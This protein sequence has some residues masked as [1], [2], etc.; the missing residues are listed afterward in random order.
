MATSST[1]S[2]DSRRQFLQVLIPADNPDQ[3]L[4]NIEDVRKADLQVSLLA[5]SENFLTH[6]PNQLKKFYK[7][8]QAYTDVRDTMIAMSLQGRFPEVLRLE[9]AEGAPDFARASQDVRHAKS[10][11]LEAESEQKSGT[12]WNAMRHACLEAVGLF[13]MSAVFMASLLASE[14]KAEDRA[15]EAA[16]RARYAGRERVAIPSCV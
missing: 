15:R 5:G 14:A 11:L 8:W 10:L 4:D 13:L 2:G 6:D 9:H 16:I 12:A 1:R 7:D 3:R